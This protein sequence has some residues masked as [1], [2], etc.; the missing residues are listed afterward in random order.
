VSRTIIRL[1]A[2]LAALSVES[3]LACVATPTRSATRTPTVTRTPTQTPLSTSTQLSTPT[4]TFTA[5]PTVVPPVNRVG[6]EFQLNSYVTGDQQRV[7]AAIASDGDFVTVWESEGQDGLG[8]G[9]F[10]K[11]FA[12]SGAAQGT[13]FQVNTYI[14]AYDQFPRVASAADGAFT[15]VWTRSNG[16]QAVDVFGRRFS[17]LGSPLGA[18]FL[19]NGYTTGSQLLP[20]IASDPSGGTVVVW[21]GSGQGDT[22]YGIFGQRFSSGGTKLGSEFQVNKYTLGYQLNPAVASDE[23]GEFVVVWASRDQDLFD[24]GVFGQ[25]FSSA[26]SKLGTEFQVNSFTFDSQELPRVARDSSSGDF[27]VV[28]RSQSDFNG[29]D[30]GGRAGIF[31]QRYADTGLKLGLEFQVNGYTT[32]DQGAPDVTFDTGGSFFVVWSSFAEDGAE[33]GI[34][35]Q[36]F[37]SSGAPTGTEFQVNSYTQGGQAAAAVAGDGTG[38]VIVAWE[39]AQED[40]SELGVFGQ[41][42]APPTVTV[43]RTPTRTSTATR[44]NTATRTPTGPSPT[45]TP[46]AS[47]TPTGPTPTPTLT[48]TAEALT[49]DAI[50]SP[51]VIGGT[52]TLTGTGFTAGSVVKLFVATSSGSTDNGPF[53]PA[54]RTQHSLTW[55]V[56]ATIALG[57]GFGTAQVINTDQGFAPSNVRGQLLFGDAADNI[58]TIEQIGG[59]GLGAASESLPLAYVE[60]SAAQGSTVT[61]AGSGFA[62]P[63]VNLF[64]ASGNVGPIDPEPGASSTAI[65]VVI[66]NG[67]PTGPASFQVVNSPFTGNVQSQAVSFVVGDTISIIAVAQSGSTVTVDGTGFSTLTVIN[68]FNDQG[69]GNV[70]NLGGLDAGGAPKIPLAF[71]DDTRFTFTVPS[72]AV[73]GPAF[74]EALNPPFIPFSSTGADPDGA[75][76]ISN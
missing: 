33:S 44:T 48:P 65:E 70:V 53:I 55:N 52:T 31:G 5:T 11:R 22:N 68:L 8:F 13:E 4:R 9:I 64:T 40:G 3:V 67:A 1:T 32:N 21:H 73:S 26:G 37:L 10:G 57:N 28:W 75:F 29:Q 50:P 36:R 15:V 69:G 46:T 74:V 61:I 19:V 58:P 41:R 30:G 71:V 34:F 62:D 56:P 47:S 54:S 17:S 66:P 20:A 25:R 7:S 18:E 14:Q 51:I 49:L 60:S 72:G 76:T 43:T 38:R 6:S 42:F 45:P 12:S 63:K 39:S 2:V 59:A 27:V 23:S 35:G 16:I 24:Y